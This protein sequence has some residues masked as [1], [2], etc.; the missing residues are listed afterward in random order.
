[1]YATSLLEGKGKNVYVRRY[2]TFICRDI[3][4]VE[5]YSLGRYNNNTPTE[6]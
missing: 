1:M 4:A 2:V 5:I 6:R 3:L